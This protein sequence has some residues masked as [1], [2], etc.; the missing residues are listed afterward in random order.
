MYEG[1]YEKLHVV[2]QYIVHEW[3]SLLPNESPVWRGQNCK[4]M[5]CWH[6]Q[7]EATKLR[8]SDKIFRGS[9][10]DKVEIR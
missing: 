4:Y 6:D 2:H 7:G 9:T 5:K 8:L 1:L 3:L 10:W